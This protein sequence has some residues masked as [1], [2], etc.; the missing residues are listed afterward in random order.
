[1]KKCLNKKLF[2]SQGIYDL[3]LVGTYHPRNLLARDILY[4]TLK[5]Y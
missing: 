4:C 2:Y 3:L 5:V 1:M